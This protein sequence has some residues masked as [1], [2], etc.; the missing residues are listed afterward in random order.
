MENFKG[1]NKELSDHDLGLV[2]KC[3]YDTKLAVTAWVFKNI[4]DHA[5]SGGSFRYLIYDRLGFEIDS[6]VPLYLAG[7]MEI[8]N[9][10]D[11]TRMEEIKNHVVE[12]KIESMKKIIHLCDE[13]DCF[14]DISTGWPSDNGYRRTCSNHYRVDEKAKNTQTHNEG[15]NNV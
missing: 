14:D 9:E 11:M 10:F 8:S 5:T 2:E 15:K 12:N 7:G 3:D 13:P 6:Y 4:V 1:F